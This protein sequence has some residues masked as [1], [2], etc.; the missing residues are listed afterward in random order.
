[1]LFLPKYNQLLLGNMDGGLHWINWKQKKS[2]K[3]VQHHTKGIF[4]IKIINNQVITLGGDGKI[5]KWSI[6]EARPIESL[7]LSNQSLRSIAYSKQH[8][9][10]AIGASDNSIYILDINS[11]EIQKTITNAH[12]NS[13]FKVI[14]DPS[15]KYLL[16]GGRDAQLNIWSIAEDY[17][18]YQNIPAHMYTIND[19]AFHPSKSLFATASRD[20]T[21]K[22]WD[23]NAFELIKVLDATKDLQNPQGH[24]NSVNSLLWTSH[25]N[26]LLSASDDR[27]ILVWAIDF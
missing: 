23:A 26:H 22:V 3:D 16:S 10:I 14:F 9:V 24:F 18:L 1:M 7:Y 27:T 21:I 20:K 25:K 11:F 12:K 8:N 2:I 15:G 19:I 13:I 6:E 5:A 4:D 17:Q